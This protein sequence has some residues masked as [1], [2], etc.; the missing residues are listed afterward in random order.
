MAGK[1]WFRFVCWNEQT[2]SKQSSFLFLFSYAPP[3]F[4][5]QTIIWGGSL[6]WNINLSFHLAVV[7]ART[8]FIKYLLSV[9]NLLSKNSTSVLHYLPKRLAL[10]RHEQAAT[11]S[12]LNLYCNCLHNF[13]FSSHRVY[14]FN[15]WKHPKAPARRRRRNLFPGIG[16][17]LNP[18]KDHETAWIRHTAVNLPARQVEHK[19]FHVELLCGVS[20]AGTSCT[21]SWVPVSNSVC[22]NKQTASKC[23]SCVG[24]LLPKHLREFITTRE[25]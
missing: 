15:L 4:V 5:I 21:D 11:P 20:L 8:S 25:L 23:R 1:R 13:N 24:R 6:S 2:C 16:A 10:G 19:L 7:S 22:F 17:R 12:W 14:P 18:G 3:S 9:P